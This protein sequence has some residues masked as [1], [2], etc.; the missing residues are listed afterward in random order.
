MRPF[1]PRATA[2]CPFPSFAHA[3]GGKKETASRHDDPAD[4]RRRHD[5]GLNFNARVDHWETRTFHRAFS[6][7]QTQSK[8]Q[9]HVPKKF[10]KSRSLC[11]NPESNGLHAELAC[12]NLTIYAGF[13]ASAPNKLIAE[14]RT[15][16]T[17]L[18]TPPFDPGSASAPDGT[19]DL[20]VEYREND[21]PLDPALKSA[22][23]R[24]NAGVDDALKPAAPATPAKKRTNAKGRFAATV[25]AEEETAQRSLSLEKENNKS[26]DE[27][28]LLAK[29]HSAESEYRLINAKAK[30]AEKKARKERMPVTHLKMEQD[31]EIYMMQMN[32]R[33]SSFSG[34]RGSYSVVA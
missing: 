5:R 33:P 10:H 22:L 14:K 27:V 7:T 11:L 26:Q 1:A 3:S 8:S 9:N 21:V 4:F 12:N 2:R 32:A 28:A 15:P 20:T 30:A 34:A 29:I 19:P 13:I 25:L 16:S 18:L 24:V 31:H 17:S 23:K 6:I